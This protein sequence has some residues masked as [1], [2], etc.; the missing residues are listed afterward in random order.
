MRISGGHGEFGMKILRIIIA[1]ALIITLAFP[2]DASAR[3]HRAKRAKA[4]TTSSIGAVS[5]LLWDSTSNHYLY[6]KSIN[7]PIFP[8][9]TTKVMTCLLVLERLSLDQYVTVSAR[10]TRVQPT[11]LDLRP[12]E[13]YKVRDLLYG[14]ILKS[15][16]DASVVLAEA[17]A[18]SE[19]KF[20][21]LMNQRARQIGAK[22]T[23]FANAH[24]LP[25]AKKQ[26]STAH[27]MSLILVQ[28]L[29]KNFFR[30][31]LTYKYHIIYS[32]DGQRSFL[33]SHNK[34]L[35]LDWNK[36]VYG[37]TGYTHEAQS[38]FVGYFIKGGHTYVVA[39]F[40]SRKRWEE[41]K[42]I[43]ERY[44]KMNL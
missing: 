41:V 14:M 1:A 7:R 39:V 19:S 3:R 5:A 2:P 8:A 21:E 37:K 38:C 42:R 33:K 10:A 32:K 12:G 30:Q 17:V 16:N 44:G 36:N 15:A 34:S 35:F 27:D 22:H 28:A 6:A 4:K 29:K 24:G 40:G 25:S 9:S 11:K 13:K 43:I 20:V 26:Y 23:R 18:G 31:A